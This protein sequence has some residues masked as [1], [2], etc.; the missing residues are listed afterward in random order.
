MKL[1]Y[2][3]NEVIV[4]K[5]KIV[6]LRDRVLK[7]RTSEDRSPGCKKCSYNNEFGLVSYCFNVCC[8]LRLSRE[9]YLS[10]NI[11][12]SLFLISSIRK[13]IKSRAEFK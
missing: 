2:D 11:D 6:I 7:I 4:F 13:E 3:G 1:E 8:Y 10:N 9:N 12:D 5:G